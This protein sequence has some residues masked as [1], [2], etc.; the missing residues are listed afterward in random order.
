MI[1]CNITD[2]LY[3]NEIVSI[4]LWY[5]VSS[6]S[7]IYSI[8]A[9]Q[10]LL[11]QSEHINQDPRLYLDVSSQPPLLIIN[12]VE[13]NDAGDY[14]CRIDTRSSR[15]KNYITHLKIVGEFA[16]TLSSIKTPV[17]PL[18]CELKRDHKNEYKKIS[19]CIVLFLLCKGVRYS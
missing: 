2:I 12:P 5:R 19:T 15:T 13:E 6:G 4:I 10:S 18:Y 11:S 1:P 7:P 17:E 16:H 3:G 14:R 9:R 8:D